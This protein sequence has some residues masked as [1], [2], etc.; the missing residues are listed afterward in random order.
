MSP[1]VFILA[2]GL[3][4]RMGRDKALLKLG[5]QPVVARLV[6]QAAKLAASVCIVTDRADKL[7]AVK[8]KN[9]ALLEDL[10]PRRGPLGG[11]YTA[12][13]GTASRWNLFLTCDMPL[14]NAGLLRRLFKARSTRCD[15]V[16][17]QVADEP[18]PQ[19]FPVLLHR[20]VAAP[21]AR[22]MRDGRLSVI[23][24]LEAV[25]CRRVVISK[26]QAAAALTN[27]N[28]PNTW[29]KVLRTVKRARRGRPA[30]SAH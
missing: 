21:V 2:G 20:R 17:F 22:R 5:G 13:R 30:R 19:P 27:V 28:T 12:L 24:L 26:R 29:R 10:V 8:L 23:G 7:R 3:S 6:A 1:T 15:A 9:A 16:C 14:M 4:S 11:I 25:A 18:R